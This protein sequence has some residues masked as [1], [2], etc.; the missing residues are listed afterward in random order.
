MRAGMRDREHEERRDLRH[1]MV[2]LLQPLMPAAWQ[3]F[4]DSR[5]HAKSHT[6]PPQ[7]IA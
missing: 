3:S 6:S 4:I 2:A 5:S 7:I 1:E